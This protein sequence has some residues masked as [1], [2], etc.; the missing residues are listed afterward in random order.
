MR[1]SRT[2]DTNYNYCNRIDTCNACWFFP[3]F[4]LTRIS[5]FIIRVATACRRDKN[6]EKSRRCTVRW[7]TPA[8]RRAIL[9]LE[10]LS[11]YFV[12]RFLYDDR[13]LPVSL[14]YIFSRTEEFIKKCRTARV[15]I[16]LETERITRATALSQRFRS[17]LGT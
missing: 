6:L 16:D 12:R 2:D 10:L 7:R 1:I 13:Y 5:N 14:V 15:Q 4:V 17:H 3:T 11:D 8:E 9:C